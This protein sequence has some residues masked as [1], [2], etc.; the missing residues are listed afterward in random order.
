MRKWIAQFEMLD[1]VEELLLIYCANSWGVTFHDENWAHAGGDA[2][3]LSGRITRETREV[4]N[5]VFGLYS[6]LGQ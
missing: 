6:P 5:V 1:E 3:G 2:W 4:V